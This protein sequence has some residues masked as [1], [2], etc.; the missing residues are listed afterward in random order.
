MLPILLCGGPRCGLSHTI[1]QTATCDL[2]SYEMLTWVLYDQP[3]PSSNFS[4]TKHLY[5]SLCDEGLSAGDV[6]RFEL[7]HCCECCVVHWPC[8][9]Q[10]FDR[11]G[12]FIL[13]LAVRTIH[14][15]NVV[16]RLHH[17][18]NTVCDSW[19]LAELT[20][21]LPLTPAD[22]QPSSSF[23]ENLKT[24]WSSPYRHV[25]TPATYLPAALHRL[26]AGRH[27]C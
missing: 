15:P 12:S 4:L 2:H 3:T 10:G 6:G 25:L 7:I 13:G 19:A 14:A 5:T 1:R 16:H 20:R 9:H 8:T 24:M 17:C 18:W 11:R 21:T 27:T 22:I 23:L 26:S